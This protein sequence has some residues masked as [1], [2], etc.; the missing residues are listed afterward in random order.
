MTY[1]FREAACC[2][3]NNMPMR[4]DQ[5]GRGRARQRFR[6][7]QDIQVNGA[8]GLNEDRAAKDNRGESKQNRKSKNIQQ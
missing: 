1:A 6:G 3:Q 7:V 5:Y 8:N 4:K 2:D